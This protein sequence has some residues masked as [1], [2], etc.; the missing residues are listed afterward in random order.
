VEDVLALEELFTQL[1][2][3]TL[4]TSPFCSLCRDVNKKYHTQYRELV[5]V[6]IEL[7]QTLPNLKHLIQG[8]PSLFLDVMFQNDLLKVVAPFTHV[9]LNSRIDIRQGEDIR[10]ETHDILHALRLLCD[11]QSILQHPLFARLKSKSRMTPEE[12]LDFFIK[13][14]GAVVGLAILQDKMKKGGIQVVTA[15]LQNDSEEK[16]TIAIVKN[17]LVNGGMFIVEVQGGKVFVSAT[18]RD[19][20]RPQMEKIS[21]EELEALPS[22][23][24]LTSGVTTKNQLSYDVDAP[25]PENIA[26]VKDRECYVLRFNKL[27]DV[28]F[29]LAEVVK[30]LCDS[31]HPDYQEKSVS[32]DC[33]IAIAELLEF[34][35]AR[36]NLLLKWMNTFAT[37][38]DSF[39]ILSFLSRSQLVSCLSAFRTQKINDLFSTLQSIGCSSA[40]MSQA[41]HVDLAE[42]KD[43]NKAPDLFKILSNCLAKYFDVEKL[44]NASPG[45]DINIDLPQV[46]NP[47]GEVKSHF[48]LLRITSDH[49]PE[50]VVCGAHI[51]LHKRAPCPVE[52]LFC[53]QGT[54]EVDVI[55]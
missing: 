34:V 28:A 30:K 2:M 49:N 18:Y 37:F 7:V 12:L 22:Q 3:D 6:Y 27:F 26:H 42:A 9:T 36:E 40:L 10:E 53:S 46:L 15:A 47:F 24:L 25:L 21:P 23:L 43:I 20:T 13:C 5:R 51:A 52:I 35:K 45:G 4:I 1:D 19:P 39:P 31:G 14:G 33:H 16:Q 29:Q 17:L 55:W 44:K 41:L 11:R 38:R 48:K 32:I 50:E 8:F 54:T